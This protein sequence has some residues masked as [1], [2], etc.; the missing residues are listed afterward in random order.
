ME[1][2]YAYAFGF[3][4]G[5]PRSTST[6]PT[7]KMWRLL[8][9]CCVL[10]LLTSLPNN[11]YAK[12]TQ[13]IPGINIT[14]AANA[15]PFHSGQ[16]AFYKELTVPLNSVSQVTIDF[17]AAQNTTDNI[18]FGIV[19]VHSCLYN[20]SLAYNT[21]IEP[22]YHQTGTNLG[23]IV[24]NAISQQPTSVFVHNNIHNVDVQISI[25]FVPYNRSDPI[26]GACSMELPMPEVPALVLNVN[27]DMTT[28]DTP[29]AATANGICTAA[30]RL[31]YTGYH[32][33]LK[34]FDFTCSSYFESIRSMMTVEQLQRNG[35]LGFAH[36]MY[37]NRRTYVTVPGTG[38]VYATL[39][40]D[41][42][43]GSLATYVPVYS[44]ACAPL[45]WE[46]KCNV[47]SSPLFHVLNM[48]LI[49]VGVV[50]AYLGSFLFCIGAAIDGFV[51]GAFIAFYVQC[52][53]WSDNV[54]TVE[55][56]IGVLCTAGAVLATMMFLFW[57][58][59]PWSEYVTQLVT[60]VIVGYVL[61]A[62][63]TSVVE[64]ADW[65]RHGFWYETVFLAVIL[66][67]FVLLPPWWNPSGMLL[68]V[69]WG[70]FA[71]MQA[72]FFMRGSHS[73]YWLLNSF[74]TFRSKDFRYK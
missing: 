32:R 25:A 73:S 10:S 3:R 60:N 47:F 22:K 56:E 5:I 64:T 11:C 38:V 28:V 26:P 67:L 7:L 23:L 17:S 55:Q 44:V 13:K 57:F 69:A 37:A 62:V 33:F 40:T 31:G 54:L 2:G 12:I 72:V 48:V 14:I 20:I 24:R 43:D 29:L 51:L 6:P 1:G 68:S 59:C 74:N 42:R 46:S 18:A 30:G 4:F 49:G 71:I 15:F 63:G 65:R 27:T 52:Q 35:Q 16:V 45:F 66:I 41:Q 58:L 19:Q 50:R 34:R 36:P 21:T 39:V 9:K 61:S 8:L 53:W 70:S